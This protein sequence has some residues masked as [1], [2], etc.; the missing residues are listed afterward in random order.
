MVEAVI[1]FLK[2]PALLAAIF[3][4]YRLLLWAY[5]QHVAGAVSVALT[6]RESIRGNADAATDL[7]NLALGLLPAW[8]F[9]GD[10]DEGL[11]YPKDKKGITEA[12]TL[13]F[14]LLAAA[15]DRG[16]ELVPSM[17]PWERRSDLEATV[18]GAPVSAITE[19]FNAACYGGIGVDEGTVEQLRAALETAAAAPVRVGEAD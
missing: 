9:R 8:M 17:T 11:R 14:D 2:Y 1:R 6:E 16:Y 4:I 19:C 12:F 7:A 10:A 15:R 13:Y 5:R 18:P 3:M